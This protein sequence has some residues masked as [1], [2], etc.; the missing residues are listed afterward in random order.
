MELS[1]KDTFKFCQITYYLGY[2]LF[3][4]GKVLSPDRLKA[5]ETDLRLLAM[6]MTLSLNG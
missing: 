5:T 2:D 3:K 6:E 4:E 1:F